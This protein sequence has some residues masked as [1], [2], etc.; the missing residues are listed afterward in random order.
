MQNK[1]L[2]ILNASNLSIKSTM[3]LKTNLVNFGLFQL[4]ECNENNIMIIDKVAIH[5][6]FSAN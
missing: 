4:R 1:S 2:G 5:A 3:Y 6:A